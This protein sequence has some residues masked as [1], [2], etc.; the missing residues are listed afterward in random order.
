MDVEQSREQSFVAGEETAVRAQLESYLADVISAM[1]VVS[2]SGIDA[3]FEEGEVADKAFSIL[4]NR[5]FCYLS[6]KRVDCYRE[7]VVSSLRKRARS[8]GA[9]RFF[10]DIGPGYHATT[11]PGLLPLSFDVGL[12][13][14]L[15]LFQ[16][17]SLSDRIEEIYRPGVHFWLV[18]D[19]IC[20]LRT[21]DIPL[22]E[23][24]KYVA[25]LR[26]LIEQL[27]MSS[28][29]SLIVE[30]EM[31]SLDEYDSLLEATSPS[32]L[33]QQLSEE[34]VDN[35]ARFLGRP[36]TRSEAL[37]RIERYRCTSQVTDALV[38]RLVRDVHMTQRATGATLGF[39]PFP[40]GDQRTQAGE[41][42]LVHGAKGRLR[43]QLITSRN[44][45][46]YSLVEMAFPNTLPKVIRHVTY[47]KIR[48][49]G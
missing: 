41:L 18:V 39:R 12:S 4:T 5:K 24:G 14:L 45:D 13:E 33:D 42:V 40:G 43:P 20:G 35:V 6:K 37:R 46:A 9:F 28:T 27:G 7:N 8:G 48:E 32:S 16:I 31:F 38:D 44:V 2:S 11:R 23:S 29:V 25:R 22:E 21:N 1:T 3:N 30:S 47:G 49:P 19:N 17:K 34:S 10:Y 15:I 36:C 26:D